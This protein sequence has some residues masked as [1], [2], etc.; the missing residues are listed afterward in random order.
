MVHGLQCSALG[1]SH[2]STA[3]VP[4]AGT[5]SNWFPDRSWFR[6]RFKLANCLHLTL[7]R[8]CQIAQFF[9]QSRVKYFMIWS[10]WLRSDGESLCMVVS[11]PVISYL[12]LLQFNSE[13]ESSIDENWSLPIRTSYQNTIIYWQFR[14][15][16]IILLEPS[17]FLFR[18][19]MIWINDTGT[20]PAFGIRANALSSFTR[21]SSYIARSKRPWTSLPM[22]S[23][24]PADFIDVV[25]ASK[26]CAPHL[27]FDRTEIFALCTEKK[28]HCRFI[29]SHRGIAR[30]TWHIQYTFHH[31]SLKN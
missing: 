31:W 21:L 24:T 29:V 1:S 7:C 30:P 22:S 27:G 14:Q 6:G 28:F 13:H 11:L 3:W 23:A 12:E 16:M 25:R 2:Q 15:L 9:M 4:R 20:F 19:R 5:H 8:V 26:T 18:H 17:R 10:F